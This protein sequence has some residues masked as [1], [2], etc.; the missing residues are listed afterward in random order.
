M[1]DMPA[2]PDLPEVNAAG[3]SSEDEIAAVASKPKVRRVSTAPPRSARPVGTLSV[4]RKKRRVWIVP[5]DVGPVVRAPRTVSPPAASAPAAAPA[6]RATR[7]AA[8]ATRPTAV[9]VGLYWKIA[10]SLAALSALVLIFVF[11][12]I[13]AKATVILVP[14]AQALEAAARLRVEP[15]ASGVGAVRG[16]YKREEVSVSRTVPVNGEGKSIEAVATGTVTLFNTTDAAQALVAT[17]RLLGADGVL[18]R[19]KNQARVSAG[20]RVEAEVYADKPGASGNIGPTKFTIP[21]LR[22]SLQDKIYAASS[23]PMTG[24][25]RNVKVVTQED[26]EAA[27]LQ[28]ENEVKEQS[29]AKLRALAG[30]LAKLGGEL[31]VAKRGKLETD[32]AV[33]TEASA[34][35][36]KLTLT[37]EAVFYDRDAARA[38]VRAKLSENVTA[39]QE[40]RGFEAERVVV[41]FVS[42]DAGNSTAAITATG[43]GTA[44]IKADSPLF[45]KAALAGLSKSRVIEYF[46]SNP[47]VESVEVTFHP[48]WVRRI[49]GAKDHIEIIVKQP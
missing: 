42:G 23:A 13:F 36:L 49:P 48:F 34:V 33:G 31:I 18:F 5:K 41:A 32:A 26:V 44:V 14:K 24:G 4:P 30:D 47:A 37:V 6:P 35:S 2:T 22:E 25:V 7:P 21:G 20:G 1:D 17:T 15:S 16:V 43:S 11:Y 10:A 38:A 28:V 8:S 39:D 46:R 27:A 9:H 29:V 19:L 40:V 3:A 45:D 12:L